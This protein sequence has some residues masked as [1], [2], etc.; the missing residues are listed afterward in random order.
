MPQTCTS[1]DAHP[2]PTLQHNSQLISR[3]PNHPPSPPALQLPRGSIWATSPTRCEKNWR[4]GS[5]FRAVRTPISPPKLSFPIPRRWDFDAVRTGDA[6]LRRNEGWG[7]DFEAGEVRRVWVGG[8]GEVWRGWNGM[9]RNV[10]SVEW[11][12]ERRREREVTRA[13]TGRERGEGTE[14][15]LS[16]E[17]QTLQHITLTAQLPSHI[18]SY[19]ANHRLHHRFNAFKIDLG[20]IWTGPGNAISSVEPADNPSPTAPAPIRHPRQGTSTCTY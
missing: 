20:D 8:R 18:P 13:K 7:L 16:Y 5:P 2:S 9:R 15:V 1:I 3:V 6:G 14:C 19:R 12:E 11:D 10:E 17:V 4:T